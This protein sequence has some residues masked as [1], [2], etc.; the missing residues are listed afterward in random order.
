MLLKKAILVKMVIEE[1][2][3]NADKNKKVKNINYNVKYVGKNLRVLEK[4]LNIAV[5]NV[6]I[7]HIEIG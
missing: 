3:K 5:K 4:K 2:V 6:N 1:L 7:Q